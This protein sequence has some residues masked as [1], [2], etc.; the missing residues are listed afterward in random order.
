VSVLLLN[1]KHMSSDVLR[2]IIIAVSHSDE[3]GLKNG[4]PTDVSLIGYYEASSLH[5]SC[6]F[7][8]IRYVLRRSAV[9][10]DSPSL[11]DFPVIQV[12]G[13]TC[14]ELCIF[15]TVLCNTWSLTL[16]E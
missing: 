16:K 12:T 10:P 15:C 3:I 14:T 4:A 5:L 13:Q 7:F 1:V 11:G 9:R 6:S 8:G 2:K